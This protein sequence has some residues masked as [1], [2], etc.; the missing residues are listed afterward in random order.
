MTGPV[1]TPAL[2]LDRGDVIG[3]GL[4]RQCI[5]PWGDRGGTVR[6]LRAGFI[7]LTLKLERPMIYTKPLS[8]STAYW[9]V[10]HPFSGRSAA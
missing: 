4:R 7:F 5:T 9:P 2:L 10:C 8:V 1:T 3:V 6:A